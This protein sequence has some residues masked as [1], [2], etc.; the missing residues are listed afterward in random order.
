MSV[1]P[2]EKIQ[3]A[4]LKQDQETILLALERQ[5]IIDIRSFKETEKEPPSPQKYNLA[6]LKSAITFLENTAKKKKSF[7]DTFL[8]PKEIASEKEVNRTFREFDG[9]KV[10]KE[11]EAVENRLN[12]LDLFKKEL[13]SDLEKL[14]PWQGL[15]T[16]LAWLTGL[17][18]AKADCGMV[19]T[20]NLKQITKVFEESSLAVELAIIK[21]EKTNTY[22]TVIY[23]V[24]EA[25][26]VSGILS[27]NGF[28]EVSLPLT[29]NTPPQ[30]INNLKNA[31][32]Q[33]SLEIE[34]EKT[35]A[36]KLLVHLTGLKYIYD[37]LLGNQAR[38]ELKNNFAGTKYT[39]IIEGWIEKSRIKE[40][41]DRLSAIVPQ[42]EIV[43]IEPEQNEAPPVVIRN[44]KA[45]GPFELI[46]RTYGA[47]S[48]NE[49][50]PTLPL[51]FFF[52]LF[53]GLCL[54]DF[55]Y[56]IML[57][58]FSVYFLK[59]YRLPAGGKNLFV[60]LLFGGLAATAVGV[61]TGSYF[62]FTPKNIPLSFLSDLQI[63]D[64]I[65]NPLVMLVFSLALGVA[66]ILFGI[67][68][69]FV[70]KFRRRE[71]FSAFCDDALW[72]FF[73]GA[74]IFWIIAGTLGSNLAGP[75]QKLSAA[76][77]ILMILTQGR[78]EKGFLKKLTGGLLS[79]YKVSGYMGDTLSYSRLL[80][81]GM[82]SAIIGSVINI[83][84]GM[85]AGVPYVGFLLMALLL[86][87]GHIFNLLVSTLG[88][89]VHSMRLQ[90]VEFFSKFFEG[91]G[92]EFNP[93]K[94]TADY[95]ILQKE[96]KLWN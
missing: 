29:E 40:L 44:P 88:A 23:L 38:E 6:E 58:L 73:L 4:A 51:S 9:T 21:R 26:T 5:E 83:L 75:A 67:L 89:F 72:F 12:T 96:E 54:G 42:I 59:K 22:L 50:D 82:S 85:V 81:L 34:E 60:L 63:I 35:K 17:A 41:K 32:Q 3:I 74:L 33:V 37:Y 28:Q 95:T 7:I 15:K 65:E 71:Y 55:G 53:F 94:R 61:L 11:I 78:N 27:K 79:L 14:L 16:R 47:P 19:K 76:G 46:T 2:M 45:F 84:S 80:A 39:F 77:A 52:A 68:L 64:P 30:E 70:N 25:E 69:Q 57:T 1:V 66:Q 92:K 20:K 49:L 56:G 87:V 31:L 43:P 86:A 91:G 13:L 10:V 8:S 24:S 36:K 90:M 48:P 93:Y 62:G 18:H